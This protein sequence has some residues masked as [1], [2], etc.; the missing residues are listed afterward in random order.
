MSK[1]VFE[2]AR[3]KIYKHQFRVEYTVGKLVGGCPS[4]QNVA[5]SWIRTK[6]GE[7]TEDLIARA[8][9][10][11]LRDK[12]GMTIDEATQQVTSQKG[13]T[14]FKRNYGTDVAKLVQERAVAGGLPGR[15]A[16]TQEQAE[17]VF[18]E[19]YIEGRQIKAGL[20]EAVNIGVAAGHFDARSWGTTNKGLMSFL[21]EHLFVLEDE[22][23]LGV[24]DPD[25]V[26]QGFVHTWRG[27]GIKREEILL[28]A[29]LEFTLAA[30]VDFTSKDVRSGTKGA[31]PDFWETLFVIAEQQGVGAS[32]SQ[33]FGTF[34]V[35]RFEPVAELPISLAAK[36]SPRPFPGGGFVVPAARR[37]SRRRCTA[38]G[39]S[40]SWAGP[41]APTRWFYRCGRWQ[42]SPRTV[43]HW[44]STAL[45]SRRRMPARE[46]S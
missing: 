5:E 42:A 26:Q 37:S 41:S 20:K 40:G 25:M 35:T 13:L 3:G 24:T 31:M 39:R 23:L 36:R 8:I 28:D 21:A 44:H 7:S 46:R 16:I 2:G 32:R 45:Q 43:H 10:S 29:V 27:S 14:G 6:M 19:L 11:A 18:G 9:D 15:A 22:I 12:P 30:D 4:D 38:S 17:L 33:G 34:K 1:S